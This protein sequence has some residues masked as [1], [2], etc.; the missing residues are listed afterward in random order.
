MVGFAPVSIGAVCVCVAVTASRSFF[1]PAFAS[2]RASSS[3]MSAGMPS[4]STVIS[5]AGDFVPSSIASAFAQIFWYTPSD[6]ARRKPKP[7]SRMGWSG[8]MSTFAT[9]TL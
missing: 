1:T 7:L 3:W 6:S 8:V 4:T 9:P 5:T 2:R